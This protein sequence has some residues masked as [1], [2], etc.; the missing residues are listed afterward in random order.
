MFFVFLLFWLQLS[1]ISH[2]AG[3]AGWVFCTSQEIGWEDCI[4]SEYNGLTCSLSPACQYYFHISI[5]QQSW[6]FNKYV[7]VE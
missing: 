4:Q 5:S 2:V 7:S 3:F 6:K 1:S